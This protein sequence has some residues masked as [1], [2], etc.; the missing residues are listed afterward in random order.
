MI[1]KSDLEVTAGKPEDTIET[2]R[3]DN[4]KERIYMPVETQ[5]SVHNWTTETFPA[6]DHGRGRLIAI[7]EET[8]ELA[9]AGGLKP[10]D[11]EK[12]VNVSLFRSLQQDEHSA[13]EEAGDVLLS[14]YAYAETERFSV[15]QELDE[16]MAFNRSRP[17]EYYQAKT[18]MK[19]R[20]GLPL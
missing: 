2:R 10:A 16:K 6:Y 4:L 11:I 9:V 1:V 5:Q 3:L 15:H 18:A 12:T 13:P 17:L 8:I 7:L 19:Q 20:R 14:L